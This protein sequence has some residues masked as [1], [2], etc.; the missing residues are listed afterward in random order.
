MTESGFNSLN[1][2]SLKSPSAAHLQGNRVAQG[3]S[4]LVQPRKAAVA[5]RLG[6]RPDP[7]SIPKTCTH[8]REAACQPETGSRPPVQGVWLG[9]GMCA[10]SRPALRGRWAFSLLLLPDPEG[11]R[12]LCLNHPKERATEDQEHHP[13]LS[14]ERVYF[15]PQPCLIQSSLGTLQRPE[16]GLSARD[17]QVPLRHH[18]LRAPQSSD[19]S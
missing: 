5:V 1:N 15:R 2:L 10:A 3:E 6:V 8:T 19:S 9:V 18:E 11:G 7:S 12:G 16:P 13:G 17:S 14:C 4:K